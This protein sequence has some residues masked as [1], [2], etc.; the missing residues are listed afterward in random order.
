MDYLYML[1]HLPYLMPYLMMKLRA[2][3]LGTYMLTR[4]YTKG[5]RI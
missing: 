5:S 4:S 1:P 3:A 2:L